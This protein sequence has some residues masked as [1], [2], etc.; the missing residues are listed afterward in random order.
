MFGYDKR[1][2]NNKVLLFFVNMALMYLMSA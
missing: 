1:D 2:N